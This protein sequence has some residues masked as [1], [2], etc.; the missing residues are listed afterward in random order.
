MIS[1]MYIGVGTGG[2]GGGQPGFVKISNKYSPPPPHT[3]F[4]FS[5]HAAVIY[6]ID[7]F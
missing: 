7:R 4:Q 2:G 3:H 6:R 5:S 1:Y